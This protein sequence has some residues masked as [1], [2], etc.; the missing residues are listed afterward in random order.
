MWLGLIAP[1]LGLLIWMMRR[2]V[3]MTH[4][5]AVFL[6]PDAG[7][8][9]KT[10]AHRPRRRLPLASIC[11]LL[12]LLSLILA[13][14]RPTPNHAVPDVH[15]LIDAGVTM[16]QATS[17]GTTRLQAAL[18]VARSLQLD[19]APRTIVPPSLHVES[20]DDADRSLDNIQA[21]PIDTR[22]LLLPTLHRLLRDSDR[23]IVLISDQAIDVNAGAM[24]ESVGGSPIDFSRILRIAPPAPLPR[25]GIESVTFSSGVLRA[26]LLQQGPPASVKIELED[27]NEVTLEAFDVTPERF[28]EIERESNGP[29]SPIQPRLARA[30]VDI[31]LEPSLQQS[32]RLHLRVNES[33][34]ALPSDRHWII[35]FRSLARAARID[36]EAENTLSPDVRR[37]VELFNQL[38]NESASTVLDDATSRMSVRVGHRSD[39]GPCIVIAK[40]VPV[41][42]KLNKR[43][44]KIE[45]VDHPVTRDVDW[46]TE[47]DAMAGELPSGYWP[48]VWGRDSADMRHAIVGVRESASTRSAASRAVWIG[49][50]AGDWSRE[51]GFVVLW[52]NMLNF[53]TGTGDDLAAQGVAFVAGRASATS[54]RERF[55]RLDRVRRAGEWEASQHL[56]LLGVGMLLA[57][58]WMMLKPRIRGPA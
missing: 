3:P 57:G 13:L 1:W 55:K 35:E 31:D 50:D 9:R 23:P 29:T 36:P 14:A 25:A 28:T 46:P 45:L 30:V 47:V 27:E 17:T 21:T 32:E 58:G 16:R 5:P 6:W 26:T 24:N 42:G 34:D 15:L 12:G 53:V 7:V 49:F 44:S 4:A 40:A 54:D 2:R 48:V 52:S 33:R 22:S 39:A 56:R 18:D 43:L 41:S 20:P 37:V 38:Q 10:D 8:L 19:S 11:F 51:V